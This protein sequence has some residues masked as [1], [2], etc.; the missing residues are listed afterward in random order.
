M[1][2]RFLAAAQAVSM[3]A[4]MTACGS[5]SGPAAPA[6]AK[7]TAAEAQSQAEAAP[8][9]TSGTYKIGLMISPLATR[10]EYYRTAELLVEK[11]GADK[12]IMDVFPSNCA[13]A[14]IEKTPLVTISS[15]SES[16]FS[17]T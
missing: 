6:A 7:D 5:S 8:E 13:L 11:H 3:V 14:S 12:F 1:L 15:P 9:E 16:P 2:K 17:I 10:E 4:G